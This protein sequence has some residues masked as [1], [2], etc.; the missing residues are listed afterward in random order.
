MF[1]IG[2]IAWGISVTRKLFGYP[3]LAATFTGWLQRLPLRRRQIVLAASAGTFAAATCK[4]RGSGIHSA[5]PNPTLEARVAA[6]EKTIVSLQNEITE[7]EKELNGESTKLR[8]EIRN[9]GQTREADDKK[10]AERI[11]ANAIGGIHISALGAS[12][13]FVGV[14]LSTASQELANLVNSWLRR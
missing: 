14:A 5:C 13:L 2:S 7:V 10:L 11:E 4:A 8:N 3:S 1:G 12:W 9:E 6:A